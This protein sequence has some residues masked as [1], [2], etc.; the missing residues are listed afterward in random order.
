VRRLLRRVR[1]FGF[2]LAALDVTQHARVHDEVIAQGIGVPNGRR[3][4]R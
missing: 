1:T 2:H 4:R 3:C